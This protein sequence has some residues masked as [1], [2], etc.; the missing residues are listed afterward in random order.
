MNTH[1]F[2]WQK[3]L[4]YKSYIYNYKRF[5]KI[6][7]LKSQKNGNLLEII[8]WVTLLLEVKVN[9]KT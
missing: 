1:S 4:E 8:Y 9:G 2:L 6:A 7:Q 3:N 5:T